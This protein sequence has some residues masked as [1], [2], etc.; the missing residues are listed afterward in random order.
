MTGERVGDDFDVT[1]STSQGS[2]GGITGLTPNQQRV[3]AYIDRFAGNAPTGPLGNLINSLDDISVNS[4]AL[5]NALNQLMP[6]NFARFTSST[7]FNNTDFLVEQMDNYLADQRG[8]DGAFMAG[9]GG[10]DYSGLTV[11]DPDTAQGL[12]E[13]RSHLLAWNPAPTT[14]LLSDSS[15]S[16]LGGV[17]MKETKTMSPAAQQPPNLWN[18]FVAGDVVLGQDFSDPETGLAHDDSTT[19]G[20][21]LG[22]DYD[23]TPPPA[24]RRFVRFQPHRRDARCAENSSATVDSYMPG[25]YA[26]YAENG[27]FANAIG[28][29]GFSSYTQSRTVSIPGFDGTANSAHLPGDQIIGDLDGGYD[30]HSGRWTFGPTAGIK[31]VHLDV[32]GYSERRTARRGPCRGA[33]R[34]RFAAGPHRRPGQLCLS[35]PRNDLHAASGRELAARVHGH[36]AAASTASSPRGGCGDL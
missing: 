3:A 11:N 24:A 12:Q 9:R 35:Q 23:V 13:V 36:G 19:G 2:F 20:V 18:V 6:L 21:R 4:S 8:A 16:M 30:F 7:A 10:I 29:Y 32:E 1:I 27:W 17:D 25:V 28:T 33:G 34:G 5:G 26:S 15:S 22:A 14:G 31:Y